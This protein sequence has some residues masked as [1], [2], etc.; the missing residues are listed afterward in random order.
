MITI[1]D[2]VGHVVQKSRFSSQIDVSSLANGIYFLEYRDPAEFH[3]G[4][5]K[6]IISR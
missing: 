5:A 2:L 6:F 3:H 1:S 4:I